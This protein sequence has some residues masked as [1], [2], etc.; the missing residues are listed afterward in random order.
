M[1]FTYQYPRPALTVDC[2]VFGFDEGELKVLLIQRGLDPFKGRWALPGGFVRLSFS[3][4]MAASRETALALAQKYHGP[5]AVARTFALAFVHAQS[6]LGHL[7][8][9][10]ARQFGFHERSD[11]HAEDFQSVDIGVVN[12]NVAQIEIMKNR[13]SQIDILKDGA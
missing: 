11:L 5:S 2:V 10:F 4:G 8:I 9:Q 7:G 3:T 12:R 6:G 13:V 1:P